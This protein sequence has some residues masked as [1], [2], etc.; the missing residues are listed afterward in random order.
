[1]LKI[2]AKPS[3]GSRLDIESV[4]CTLPAGGQAL[5]VTSDHDSGALAK[6]VVLGRPATETLREN[7]HRLTAAV[8]PL[9]Q[10][11]LVDPDSH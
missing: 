11:H 3:W 4:R 10:A 2:T 1:V 8:T 9:H 7:Y 6:A 5:V